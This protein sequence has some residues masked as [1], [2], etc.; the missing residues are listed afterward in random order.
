MIYTEAA[1]ALLILLLQQ[2][3]LGLAGWFPPV[4]FY[5]K[6]VFL[7]R[8]SYMFFCHRERE[9]SIISMC[10]HGQRSVWIAAHKYNFSLGISSSSFSSPLFPLSSSHILWRIA[11]MD[12][13][14][15]PSSFL[16]CLNISHQC[17]IWFFLSVAFFFSLSFS[18]A[19]WKNGATELRFADWSRH[20]SA[21]WLS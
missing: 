5:T 7:R 9:P 10:A 2:Q 15:F 20:S 14:P 12:L 6:C 19:S 11:K 1:T 18:S 3:Q 13:S 21:T 8:R 16:R 17:D 4:F